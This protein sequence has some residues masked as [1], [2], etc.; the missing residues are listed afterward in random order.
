MSH[1]GDEYVVL[2]ADNEP[3]ETVEHHDVAS[4]DAKALGGHH[5]GELERVYTGALS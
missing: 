1:D 5:H 4:L 2:Q 3:A